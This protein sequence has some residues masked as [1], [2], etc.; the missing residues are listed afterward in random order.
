MLAQKRKPKTGWIVFAVVLA[1]LLGA[2]Y[3]ARSPIVRLWPP[4]ALF[5]QTIGVPVD[6]PGVGLELQNISSKPS[7]ENGVMVL[8]IDG[9]ILNSSDRPRP[10]PN[11]RAELRSAGGKPLQTWTSAP[12][13]T[14]ILPGEIATFHFADRDP[15]SVVEVHVTFEGAPTR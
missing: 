15:G 7:L 8:L 11:L 6:P 2:G 12:S 1:A 5:Y 13:S 10:V 9:Q 4:A 14:Q 3:F